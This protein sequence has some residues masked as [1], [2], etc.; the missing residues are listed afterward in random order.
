MSKKLTESDDAPKRKQHRKK[1]EKV[2]KRH[3]FKK[4]KKKFYEK[5]TELREIKKQKDELRKLGLISKVFAEKVH[6]DEVF[7]ITR[8]ITKLI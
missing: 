3:S 4:N 6:A 5:R 1:R 2:A 7:M 8:L